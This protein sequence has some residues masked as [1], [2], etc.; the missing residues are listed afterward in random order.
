M[1]DKTLD[2]IDEIYQKQNAFKSQLRNSSAAERIQK[3]KRIR[4]AMFDYRE[5]IQ[6]AIHLDFNKHATEVD[7]TE[8]YV[9]INDANH[10]IKHLKA[11]MKPKRAKTPFNMIGTVGHVVYEPKGNA[12]I[13]APWNFPVNLSLGPLIYAIAAGNTAII[14]PSELTPHTSA[15]LKEII[16]TLF[17]EKEVAVINGGVEVSTALLKL[18]FDHIFFTG[19]PRVGKIV[20]EAAAK[21]LTSV[22]L[23]LGGKSPTIIDRGMD[24][25]L[26]A[27]RIAWAKWINNG[28]TCIAPDYVLVHR[29]DLDAFITLLEEKI[30][31]YYGDDP[32]ASESYARIIN[33][34]NTE[35]LA[36]LIETSAESKNKPGKLNKTHRYVSPTILKAPDLNSE[37]MSEEIFGPVLPILPYDDLEECIQMIN[38]KEKPLSLYIYS[39]NKKHTSHILKNTSSGGVVINDSVL[40]FMNNELPFG[41]VNHSGLGK[42]H[43]VYGFQAFSNA[44]AVLEQ[45]LKYSPL[46]FLYPPYNT[47]SEKLVKLMMKWFIFILI[48]TKYGI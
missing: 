9:V 35:R 6:K 21:H 10:T 36:K 19:S 7:I 28:Q 3:I 20:M 8:L 48:V 39:K 25:N 47:F 46:A 29:S 41:G 24:L 44:K 22:T 43:G 38:K 13:I 16:E 34:S 26:A 23:E 32:E 30:K 42:S 1:E 31:R 5:K 4:Q 2:R 45:K 33:Q 18:K 12:L 14:K 17:D 40:H 37:V 15:L 11:W 27:K